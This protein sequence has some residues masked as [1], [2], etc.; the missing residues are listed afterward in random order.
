[1]RRLDGLGAGQVRKDPK[2]LGERIR[3]ARLDR[4]L[5]IKALA[6]ILGVAANTISRWKLGKVKPI[7]QSLERVREVL[8]IELVENRG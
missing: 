1:M 6:S 8:G 2:T 3:K 7:R 4:G 5:T